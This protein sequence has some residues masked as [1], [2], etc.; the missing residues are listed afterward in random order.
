MQPKFVYHI[1]YAWQDGLRFGFGHE[2][3]GTANMIYQSHQLDEIAKGLRS[4]PKIEPLELSEEATISIIGMNMILHE[5]P[6]VAPAT[7]V[8]PVQMPHRKRF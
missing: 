1:G 6:K 5:Q 8:N 7:I 2:I 3:I 4:H